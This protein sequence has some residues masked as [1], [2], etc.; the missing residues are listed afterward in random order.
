M[1]T[2]L[3]VALISLGAIVGATLHAT[4]AEY[5]CEFWRNNDVEAT[6]RL[7]SESGW[8]E[9]M[10]EWSDQLHATCVV[11]EA[12]TLYLGA[13]ITTPTYKLSRRWL[14]CFLPHRSGTSHTAT[15]PPQV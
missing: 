2:D 6:C 5:Q 11:A 10:H 7:D 13:Y 1:R 8:D 3:V 15:S 14:T 12:G 9:C 4:A